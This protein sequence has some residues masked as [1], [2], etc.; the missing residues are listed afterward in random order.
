[1]KPSG[2]LS[3]AQLR[4]AEQ[5]ARDRVNAEIPGDRALAMRALRTYTTRLARARRDHETR[6]VEEA[7]GFEEA[8]SPDVTVR[9]GASRRDVWDAPGP[10][11]L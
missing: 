9:V 6:T 7:A 10:E 2:A 4:A 5:R 1:M 11:E 8:R 3:L